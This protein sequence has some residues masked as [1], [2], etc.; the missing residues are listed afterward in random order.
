MSDDVSFNRNLYRDMRSVGIDNVVAP[1][2]VFDT[3][4]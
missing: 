1:A 2:L 4:N 3:S